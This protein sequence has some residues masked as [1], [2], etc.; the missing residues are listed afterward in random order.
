MHH[1][2]SFKNL[3]EEQKLNLLKQLVRMAKADGV[4]KF[5]EFKYLTEVAEMMGITAAQLDEILE[6]DTLTHLPNTRIERARQVYRLA[7]MMQIDHVIAEEEKKL[8]I[9]LAVIL[10]FHPDGVDKMLEEMN[11]NKGGVLLNEQLEEIFS[12]DLNQNMDHMTIEEKVALIR[13]LYQ[14]SKADNKIEPAEKKFLYELALSIDLPI[15]ALEDILDEKPSYIK[16]KIPI[17]FEDRIL[18]I[19]RLAL[20]M[21]IDNDVSKEEIQTL[22]SIALELGLHPEAVTV[23]L[24]RLQESPEGVLE[25]NELKEIFETYH[26]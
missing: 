6:D 10:N 5:V 3:T 12:Q 21:K 26:N 24:E 7:V 16:E 8:L 9:N 15:E 23:L 25:Y 14:I 22:K 18:Q 2:K 19:Y 17:S 4:F 13:Q 1:N 11:K 20:M